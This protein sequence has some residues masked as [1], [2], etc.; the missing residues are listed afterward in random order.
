ML[1]ILRPF[2]LLLLAV[3]ANAE[4]PRV[5]ADIAPVHGLVSQVMQ[6]VG[7]PE[8]ILL[9]GVSPHGYALRPSQARALQKAGLV[10][11]I[12]PELTPWLE[13]PVRSL[14]TQANTLAL[15][16]HE[17]TQVLPFR[18]GDEDGAED[19]E[20]H[21]HG[22]VDEHDH[23]GIDPHAWLDPQN[24]QIW[25]GLIAEAL[26]EIDPENAELYQAN[27]SK[28][29]AELQALMATLRETLSPVQAT[30]FVTYHDAYQYFENR[31]GL[32][33]AGFVTLSD[34]AGA[35]P[36]RVSELRDH[37]SELDVQCA[38]SEPGVDPGVLQGI[39]ASDGLNLSTL[40]PMGR[41]LP[42][43]SGFYSDLLRNL[44]QN[45]VDCSSRR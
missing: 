15:L 36:A 8:L 12:G 24:A 42:L 11:W 25:L 34:G 23:G 4:A 17:T 6:G 22:H 2:V 14:A 18:D 16:S 7:E 31:F 33:N 21:D 38:F 3:P 41:D 27:A 20:G 10:V 19:E 43:G 45:F 28:A 32:N 5:V 9:P 30:P 13:K 37:L 39:S 44:T 35:S 40:D 29:Q 1:T 26:V